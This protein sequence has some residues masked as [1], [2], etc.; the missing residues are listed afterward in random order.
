[1]SAETLKPFIQ[2]T[3]AVNIY[4]AKQSNVTRKTTRQLIPIVL[5]I[6][7][8]VLIALIFTYTIWQTKRVQQ[9][10]DD[11][12]ALRRDMDNLQKRLGLNY[13]EDLAE[14]E[15]ELVN[16]EN[17]DV[18]EEDD[19]DEDDAVSYEDE[20]DEDSGNEHTDYDEYLD[21]INQ[22]KSVTQALSPDNSSEKSDTA[23]S[24]AASSSSSSASNDDNVFEDFTSYNDSKK[25]RERKTR[26]IAEM[27]NELPSNELAEIA[28]NQSRSA[29]QT[30]ESTVTPNSNTKQHLHKQRPRTREGRQRLLVRK[31]E[32]TVSAKSADFPA[33]SRAAAHFHLNRKVPQHESSIRLHS[34]QGDMYMGHP[35]ASSDNQWQQHFSVHNGVLTVH[36]AGLYY[37]YAQICYNNTHDQNGFIIF[38]DNK[39]FLQ[40]LNTVPTNMPKVHTCHTGGLIQLQQ[41]ES[42]HLRDIHRDRN[43]ML[44]DD[45]NRSFFGIIRV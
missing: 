12:G 26:S 34:Y 8:L 38:H 24:T 31:G 29:E 23:A 41:H 17:P 4:P 10:E 45:N 43:V 13:L 11:L 2:P 39:A 15:K 22:E 9:L 28:K 25:K 30:K 7:A 21:L 44:R 27:R 40:C 33:A 3:S 36:Q 37:V 16:L 18:G 6:V 42:I 19:A 20:D 14:F 35:T 5:S 1:M 32:S